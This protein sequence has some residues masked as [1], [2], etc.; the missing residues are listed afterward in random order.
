MKS[1]LIELAD[2]PNPMY[3]VYGVILLLV[4][5]GGIILLNFGLIYIRALFSGA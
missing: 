1:N 4:L 2:M 5:V 3:F